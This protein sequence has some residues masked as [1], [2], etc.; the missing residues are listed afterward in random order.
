MK[1]A[2]VITFAL[3]G[4]FVPHVL[5]DKPVWSGEGG[6]PT[7]AEKQQHQEQMRDKNNEQKTVKLS[8]TMK[9][10]GRT[11]ESEAEKERKK[12]EENLRSTHR[13]MIQHQ[14]MN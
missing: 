9:E 14:P 8:P 6:K 4:M 10:V 7:E 13:G 12:L 1:K 3:T 11:D 5:A 2:V